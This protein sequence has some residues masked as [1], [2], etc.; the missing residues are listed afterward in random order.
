M[1]GGFVLVTRKDRKAK[2]KEKNL[3]IF[4]CVMAILTSFEGILIG[5]GHHIL[6]LEDKWQL[7]AHFPFSKWER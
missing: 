2:S 6:G 3:A 5:V 7:T 4:D 1:S